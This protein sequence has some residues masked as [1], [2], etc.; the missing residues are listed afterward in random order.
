[1][2]ARSAMRQT[3]PGMAAAFALVAAGGLVAGTQDQDKQPGA[4]GVVAGHV[5][6]QDV[7]ASRAPR[8]PTVR[9][10]RES[11]WWSPG[12]GRLLPAKA[13]YAT[14][15][16]RFALLNTSGPLPTAGHPFFEPIGTN[17][18]ACVTCHQPADGMSVSV[19]TVQRRWRETNGKDPLFA[20][21]DGSNCPNLPQG[22]RASHS[23]L[24]ERG[25]FRIFLPWPPRAADG[26]RLTPE[27]DIEV[28]KDPT[29]CNLD[30][31]Y[32]LTSANPIVSVFR[33]P[34][35]VMNMRYV[36]AVDGFFNIKTGMPFAKDPESGAFVSMQL[37]SDA[38]QP[39]LRTQAVEA[40]ITHLQSETPPRREQ[41][42]RIV[43]FENQLIGAQGWDRRAGVL[44]GPGA[45]PGLGPLHLSKE[46]TGQLGDNIHMPVFGKFDGWKDGGAPGPSAERAFRRSV[47]RGAD[48]FML[49]TFWIRD[50]T[51]LN[52]VGLGNPIKRTCATC[53]NAYMTGMDLAPGWMDIGV[54]NR[55]WADPNRDLPLFKLTCRAGA[56]PHPYLGRVVY[57]H[58][59]GRALISGKCI[60]I[61]SITM[62][63]MRGL[64]ARAPLF[65]NGSAKDLRALVDFYDR[66]FDIRY[67]EQE[68]RDLINFMSLL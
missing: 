47:A 63:Q 21:V 22:R 60:D 16:G 30:K 44:D 39:T 50:A 17:G 51:H 52:T 14:D 10:A 31:V 26:T 12:D 29:G 3:L 23:L 59:P 2:A 33:R 58:D 28:V 43:A 61:G 7:Q 36:Q 9:G 6:A 55:P 65:A 68:K 8:S 34:R 54:N 40:A 4:T 19:A 41:L 64:S 57:T 15:G 1:M 45:P 13:T 11:D 67:T 32:G 56:D 46:P 25:L 49:R 35:P 20:A 27:F 18:R 62:Q 48:V 42:D 38:R 53:H 66:R 24:L 37:M 5:P